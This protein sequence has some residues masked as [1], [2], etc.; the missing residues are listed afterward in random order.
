RSSKSFSQAAGEAGASRI[1]GGIHYQFDNLG[2][3][4]CGRA[5][6]R[7]I[8]D[9]HLKPLGTS[10]AKAVAVRSAL[11][12]KSSDRSGV[13]RPGAAGASHP[14]RFQG[15]A[16]AEHSVTLY[17]PPGDAYWPIVISEWPTVGYPTLPP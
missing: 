11:R 17:Y 2:G 5:I 14:K 8:F 13:S 6:S 16:P 9:R 7:Y 12:P 3:L 10:A 15:G 4:E 1:Y